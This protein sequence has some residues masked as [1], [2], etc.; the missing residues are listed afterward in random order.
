MAGA[1]ATSPSSSGGRLPAT[2]RSDLNT[3]Y[4]Y[5]P[6]IAEAVNRVFDGAGLAALLKASAPRPAEVAAPVAPHTSLQ[7]DGFVSV[8]RVPPPDKAADESSI[9]PYLR[10]RLRP[11]A[12]P[13]PWQRGLSAAILVRSN[14]QGQRFAERCGAQAFR[15]SGRARAPSATPRSSRPSS[16]PAGGGTPRQHPGVAAR[17]RHAAGAHG[18]PRRLLP[19]ARSRA[20]RALAPRAR[21]RVPPRPAAHAAAPTSRPSPPPAPIFSRRRASTSSSAQRPS[22]R[23]SADAETTLTDFTAFVESFITRDVADTSTVK[24]LTIHRSKGL[25]FDFVC[26][27]SSRPPA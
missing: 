16:T 24:I 15:L 7:P 10:S 23:P 21:R 27:R 26:C 5:C 14:D 18:L 25:G 8:E 17:L 12:P 6:Q 11:P 20:P 1:A 13:T 9:G 3:S 22:S 19:A 4:R 2:M